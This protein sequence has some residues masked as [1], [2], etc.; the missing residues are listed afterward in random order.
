MISQWCPGSFQ[1]ILY[2]KYLVSLSLNTCS[3]IDFYLKPNPV[4]MWLLAGNRITQGS[5]ERDSAKV[6]S[7][8]CLEFG[9]ECR[10]NK[11][12]LRSSELI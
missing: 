2:F 9:F 6:T 5:A 11:F 10:H 1:I 4:F 12:E 8:D 7:A 3:H